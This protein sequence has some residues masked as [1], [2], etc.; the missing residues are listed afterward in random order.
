M[1]RAFQPVFW[2]VMG[3]TLVDLRSTLI[4]TLSSHH[5][6]YR[7]FFLF[8]NYFV[9]IILPYLYSSWKHLQ[10][11]INSEMH[12][13]NSPQFSCLLIVFNHTL[14]HNSKIHTAHQF[15]DFQSLSFD[16][17][18]LDLYKQTPLGNKIL[19]QYRSFL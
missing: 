9:Q 12:C 6:T 14:N 15:C 3:S 4:F 11:C 18:Q 10:C 5:F 19:F 1:V 8:I 16:C 17:P 2:K 13:S 7:L